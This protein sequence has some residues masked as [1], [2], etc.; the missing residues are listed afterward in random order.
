MKISKRFEFC[1][2]IDTNKLDEQVIRQISEDST[3]EEESAVLAVANRNFTKNESESEKDDLSSELSAGN[4]RKVLDDVVPSISSSFAS[5][6]LTSLRSSSRAEE[7]KE[8]VE[9]PKEIVLHKV[10]ASKRSQKASPSPLV[11][12]EPSVPTLQPVLFASKSSLLDHSASPTAPEFFK[13]SDES[14]NQI[15]SSSPSSSP[16]PSPSSPSPSE[17]SVFS[18]S[19]SS[20][21]PQ[22]SLPPT[23]SLPVDNIHDDK[24]PRSQPITPLSIVLGDATCSLPLVA[25]SKKLFYDHHP[26]YS[27]A[28]DDQCD[29]RNRRIDADLRASEQEARNSRDYETMRNQTLRLDGVFPADHVSPYYTIVRFNEIH[30]RERRVVSMLSSR[31]HRD[32]CFRSVT[33][34]YNSVASVLSFKE[35]EWLRTMR[36]KIHNQTATQR[37]I[38]EYKKKQNELVVRRAQHH[39]DFHNVKYYS[40][41]SI[42]CDGCMLPGN[43]KTVVKKDTFKDGLQIRKFVGDK[44]VPYS[45][46]GFHVSTKVMS[47][48]V[49]VGVAE[50]GCDSDRDGVRVQSSVFVPSVYVPLSWVCSLG[51]FVCELNELNELN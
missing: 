40:D 39:S 7:E 15:E 30:S 48:V 42:Y 20:V 37:E 21:F 2:R 29:A 27:F 18:P 4:V 13:S 32:S 31:M 12:S 50:A 14:S 1:S 34:K 8:E 46:A 36:A 49:S 35:T 33:E 26:S 38:I 10:W 22:D 17:S 16:S 5:S 51:L 45:D 11:S 28:S 44:E 3:L 23:T 6:P 9:A 24:P 25:T 41:K 47:R 43:K 19:E